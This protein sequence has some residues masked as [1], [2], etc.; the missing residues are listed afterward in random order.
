V[1]RSLSIWRRGAVLTYEE[2]AGA[3]D[4]ETFVEAMALDLFQIL[5]GLIEA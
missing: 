5:S 2:I 4:H 1:E 3:A